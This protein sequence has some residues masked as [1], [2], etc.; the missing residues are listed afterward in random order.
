VLLRLATVGLAAGLLGAILG[1]GGGIIVVPLLG[2]LFAFDQRRAAATSMGAIAITATAGSISYAIQGHQHPAEAALL[3]VPAAIGVIAGT[4]LQ[5]RVPLRGLQLLFAAFVV[6]VGIRLLAPDALPFHEVDHRRWW[7]YAVGLGIGVL[8]GVLAGLFGI[9]GGIL[10]VPAYVL[11][12]ALPQI[13]AAAT[14]LLAMLPAS[15]LG[16]WRQTRYGNLDVRASLVI[17][18]TSVGGVVGGIAIAERLPEATLRRIFGAFLLLTA[19]QIA[20]SARRR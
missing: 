4:A 14:S 15:Y 2:L 9:G 7:V 5:Q 1:V 19:A 3:G 13:D 12:L 18:L 11:L 8:G 17:G 10:F 16:A 6:V 20:A